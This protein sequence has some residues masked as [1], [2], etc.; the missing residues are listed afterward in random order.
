V[1][2]WIPLVLVTALFLVWA[3]RDGGYPPTQWLPGTLFVLGLV[4]VLAFS[5]TQPFAGR[6][7]V[8]LAFGLFAA[9]T[10][11]SFL[12]IAWAD[13]KGDAWDGANRTLLYLCVF[14]VFAWRP[15]AVF[16]ASV[17]LAGFI[18]MTAL[19]GAADFYRAA[20]SS[21]LDG[22]FIEGRLSTPISYPNATA[23]LF[24]AC[25]APA[26]MLAAR[27]EV[28]WPLRGLMLACAGVL[29]ELAV[30][31]QSRA[32]L[33]ALP[34]VL[35]VFLAVAPQRLRLLPP[36]AAVAVAVGLGMQRLLDVHSAVVFDEGTRR[37]LPAAWHVVAWTALALAVAGIA[38]ALVDRRIEFSRHTTGILKWGVA[39]AT[40]VALL[41]TVPFAAPRYDHLRERA[42]SAWTEFKTNE[43]SDQAR[44]ISANHLLSGFQSSR[45]DIWRVAVQEFTGSPVWGVG[46]D[47]FAV[48]YLRAR[49][50]ANEP[51]HQHSLELR[52]LAQTGLVGVLLF[53][54]FLALALFAAARSLSRREPFV[55]AM[56]AACLG[57]FAY[58]FIH[59]SVDWFWEVPA[60]GAPAIAWLGLAG[61]L[62]PDEPRLP[63][64]LRTY[65]LV[66]VVV[67]AVL[68][69][70]SVAFPWL[71]DEQ[72]DSASSAWAANPGAAFDRLERARDL[73]PLTDGADLVAGVIASRLRERRRERLAFEN[74]LQ[75]NP[76]NWYAHFELAILDAQEGHKQSALSRLREAHALNPREP[77]IPLVRRRILQGKAVSQTA[78]D[79]LFLDR[80][81]TL[82][83][84]RQR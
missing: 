3:A 22:F 7:E 51:T 41:A 69:A 63:R 60:L 48:D 26:L 34:L 12:S 13:V 32:S 17:L 53:G 8:G 75:R 11:W 81:A 54:G 40:I 21:S 67:V 76:H 45:Y 46:V 59:G 28:P 72:I 79:R 57:F 4:C 78:I 58:W 82:T 43:A 70:A 20:H 83:G 71:A 16:G 5:E 15:R 14:A 36:M 29:A 1:V 84:V 65:G 64:G 77:V 66:P 50:T 47:N 62:V 74:V 24:L 61:Q 39:A 6:R 52:V 73:N 30:M 37:T 9:F 19:I 56:S 55:A 31:S 80:T 68:G 44:S 25:F 42:S 35:L 33:F 23:A 38:I 18:A 10:A 2:S 49:R 27:R